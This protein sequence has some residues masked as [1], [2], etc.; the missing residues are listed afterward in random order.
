MVFKMTGSDN[1]RADIRILDAWTRTMGNSD[2]KIADIESIDDGWP[3]D[4]H[5]DLSNRI[6]KH[7]FGSIAEHATNI[8]GILIANHNSLGI[9][10]INNYARF[11]FLYISWYR[12]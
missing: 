7:G 1:T 2:Q 11:K 12:C 5:E 10:G 3:R 9:A 4:T 6:T 8:A